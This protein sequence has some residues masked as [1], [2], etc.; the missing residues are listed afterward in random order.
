MSTDLALGIIALT[1]ALTT[2]LAAL[3]D[4]PTTPTLARWSER[5]FVPWC[6]VVFMV[7]F[8]VLVATAIHR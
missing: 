7:D 3:A 4:E 6:A 5:A 2:V 1:L 8:W